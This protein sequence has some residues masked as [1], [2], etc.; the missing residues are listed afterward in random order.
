MTATTASTKGATKDGNGAMSSD[1]RAETAPLFAPLSI[2]GLTLHDRIVVS[3]MCQYSAIDGSATDWHGVHL[4]TLAMS[5]AGLLVLEATGVEARGR[6][7]HH[8]LGLYSDANEAA[9]ARVLTTVRALSDMPLGIQLCHAG[10]KASTQRPW[11]GRK[12]LT[13]AEGAWE[14]IAPSAIPMEE[15]PAP[16]EMT[17]DDMGEVLAAF[18][19]TAER[20][21]RLGFDWLELHGA[22]GYLLS[23]FISPLSN[24]RSDKYGGDIEGRMRFPL[25]VVRAVREIWPDDRPLSIKI[26]GTDWAEG[27]STLEDVTT[28]ARALKEAGVDVA[29]VSGGAVVANMQIPAGPGYQVPFAAHVKK[30][31]GIITGAVGL[32]TDPHFAQSLI[33]DGKADLVYLARGFLFD[34]RWAYHAAVALGVDLPYPPQYERASPPKWAPGRAFHGWDAGASS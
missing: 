14:T 4:G 25:A 26:N 5:G 31:T 34:P 27:G 22:H 7:T 19:K 33:A 18:V 1:A 3:P 29:V 13:P 28:F 30:E 17:E 16:R 12:A 32:I 2:R 11:E 9:L 6:I 24:R 21:L 10:R 23:S 8:C 15:A 20:A